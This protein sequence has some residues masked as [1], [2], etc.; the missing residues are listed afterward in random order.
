[1]HSNIQANIINIHFVRKIQK[2][3]RAMRFNL[4]KNIIIIHFAHRSFGL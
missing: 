1:M 4:H 2:L 3:K